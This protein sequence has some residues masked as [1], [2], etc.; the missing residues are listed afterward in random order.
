[1]D[2]GQVSFKKNSTVKRIHVEKRLNDIIN[3]L[4]KT[5]IEK[6]NVDLASERLQRDRELK[7]EE[8]QIEKLKREQELKEIEHER[9]LAKL[10]NYE[11]AMRPENMVSNQSYGSDVDVNEI[12]EDFM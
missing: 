12:E 9:E 4:N 1:M 5:K 3:R 8:R 7:K 10:R 6:T 11:G 2:I